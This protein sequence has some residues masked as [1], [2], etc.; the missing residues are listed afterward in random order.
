[1]HSPCCTCQ[2]TSAPDLPAWE[3][4]QCC[5]CEGL[6]MEDLAALVDK[7]HCTCEGVS[8]GGI[9]SSGGGARRPGRRRAGDIG[10]P[11]REGVHIGGGLADRVGSPP[12][13]VLQD[14]LHHLLPV[15]GWQVLGSQEPVQ[16]AILGWGAGF[17]LHRQ[18][19]WGQPAGSD[20][21]CST[22][23]WGRL[24]LQPGSCAS[25]ELGRF[26]GHLS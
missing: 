21:S 14:E 2:L 15:G 26:K 9:A 1:M 18:A 16:H 19:V 10:A 4:L 3:D 11:P 22:R 25:G 6:S 7:Q 12:L 20:M 5:T 13:G 23:K 8:I 24:P 17:T